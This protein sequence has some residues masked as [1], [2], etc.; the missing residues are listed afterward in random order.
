ML[1]RLSSRF[2]RAL[3]NSAIRKLWAVLELGLVVARGVLRDDVLR[4]G[5][6]AIDG[7]DFRAWLARH[8]ASDFTLHR[9]PIVRE[10][11]QCY[12]LAPGPG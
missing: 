6:N 9:A 2:T 11:E 1:A 4:Q 7:E 3:E 10:L 8:G 5:F 12:A